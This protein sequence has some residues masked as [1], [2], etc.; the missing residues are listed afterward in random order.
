[1][2]VRI[3]MVLLVLVSLGGSLFAQRDDIVLTKEKKEF[4]FNSIKELKQGALVVRL[5]T[6]H[7]KIAILERTLKDPNLSSRQ[8]DRH[9]GIL[10][11]TIRVRDEFN[12]ALVAMFNKSFNFCPV[13][14]MYDTSS[15]TLKNGAKTGIFLNAEKELDANIELKEDHVFLVN[16]KK[17]S[18]EFPFDVLRVQKLKER[19]EEPFP[20]YVSIRESWI[21]QINSPRAAAAVGQLDQKLE[22]FYQRAL[23]YDKK[24]AERAAR[25]AANKPFQVQ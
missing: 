11:G 6:N 25:N 7:R 10:K 12:N 9:E 1:M 13:Y 5:K 23:E 18:A 3:C 20:Y 22:A 17:K 21:N 14:F 16:Y 19:L 2:V 8:R 24:M 15:T 4:A